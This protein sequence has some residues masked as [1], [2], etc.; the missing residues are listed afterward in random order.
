MVTP[1]HKL[2]IK[3]IHYATKILRNILI[4]FITETLATYMGHQRF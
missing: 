4:F 2:P 3:F 1:D